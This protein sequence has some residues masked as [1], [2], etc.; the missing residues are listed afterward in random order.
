M[1][2][3]MIQHAIVSLRPNTEWTMN[4]HDVEGIIWHTEGV[5][6]LTSAEVQAEVKRLEKAE[7]QAVADREA[8]KASALTKLEALGLTADEAAAI[9]GF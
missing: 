7:A 6:P 5:E 9:A 1:S 8:A 2:E 4:G 3:V